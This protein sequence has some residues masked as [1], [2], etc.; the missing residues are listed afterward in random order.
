[1]KSGG[2]N[3]VGGVPRIFPGGSEVRP[4]F[5]LA[6]EVSTVASSVSTPAAYSPGGGL[7]FTAR[8]ASAPPLM[9]LSL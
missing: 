6:A 1:M 7:G 8:H 3:K 5:P 4:R 2:A 9:R